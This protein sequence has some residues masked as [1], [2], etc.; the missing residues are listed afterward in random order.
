MIA[1]PLPKF[2]EEGLLHGVTVQ[3][4][5]DIRDAA[6]SQDVASIAAGS[7]V[8]AGVR[9]DG[10]HYRTENDDAC[11]LI[12]VAPMAHDIAIYSV[13]ITPLGASPK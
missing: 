5:D 11:L 4:A 12:P 10:A 8:Y 6:G 9:H 2:A 1:L 13:A 3:S 7:L